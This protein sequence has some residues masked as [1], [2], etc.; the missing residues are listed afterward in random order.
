MSCWAYRPLREKHINAFKQE[1]ETMNKKKALLQN[2]INEG[3]PQSSK[4]IY[5][6]SEA[7]S[8]SEESS[9]QQSNKQ[10]SIPEDDP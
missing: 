8:Q 3:R 5:P 1:L 4:E 10:A 9:S 6:I 2:V 7:S